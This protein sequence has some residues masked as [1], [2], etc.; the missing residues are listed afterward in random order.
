MVPRCGMELKNGESTRISRLENGVRDRGRTH[1]YRKIEEIVPNQTHL[2][3]MAQ[4]N[5]ILLTGGTHNR[6]LCSHSS[7]C[8]HCGYIGGGDVENVC[9]ECG[10]KTHEGCVPV[11]E[12]GVCDACK[13]PKDE[14]QACE[15]CRV[16]EGTTTNDDVDRLVLLA[17]FHGRRWIPGED[18]D[19]RLL[20]SEDS[21]VAGRLALDS[22]TVF[23]PKQL[24][25]GG[26]KPMRVVV[27]GVT[28]ISLPMM[29]HS[30]CVH[31]VF[32][33]H[34]LPTGAEAWQ[35]VAEGVDAPRHGSYSETSTQ[36]KL[37]VV[38]DVSGCAFCGSTVG[39]QLFCYGHTNSTRGC[40]NCN[41]SIRPNFTYTSFHPSCAVHAGMY[42]VIDPV[43]GGCGM[44]CHRSMSKFLPRVHKIQRSRQ[45][46]AR[47]QRI[48][49]WLQQSSG[50]HMDLV[51]RLDPA[52][53]VM[54]VSQT[55]PVVG[56][57]Y[58]TFPIARARRVVHKRQSSEGIHD[59]GTN[60]VEKVSQQPPDRR[61]NAH[62][63]P[64][65]EHQHD[66]DTGDHGEDESREDSTETNQFTDGT[67]SGHSSS[68][69]RMTLEESSR[70]IST[71]MSPMLLEAIDVRIEWSI[72]RALETRRGL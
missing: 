42:R 67:M 3:K 51:S 43:D 4:T 32:Q 68:R 29:V 27:G 54:D 46:S 62:A 28:Y 63:T 48:E 8:H 58:D 18:D 64:R 49:R 25:N 60:V 57:R 13:F 2:A 45:L 24:P 44:M 69:G 19:T 7:M 26:D 1:W 59:T 5:R 47:V 16:S 36:H 53:L 30:W 23:Q 39:F 35:T 71:L 40:N 66:D 22:S 56:S 70:I 11:F 38:N 12:G 31:S 65:A 21:E 41:W 15:I 50:F 61:G 17:A 6:V 10:V 34:P 20:L 55:L 33:M 72:A 52:T 37:G 14:Q 9:S